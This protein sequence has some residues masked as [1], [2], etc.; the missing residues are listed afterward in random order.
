P[1]PA[2]R[3]ARARRVRGRARPAPLPPGPHGGHALPDRRG[4]LRR[5][6][7]R[8]AVHPP[9]PVA[10]VVARPA[11]PL[12]RG[13]GGGVVRPLVGARGRSPGGAPDGRRRG[14]RER[15]VTGALVLVGTPI[16]N[17]G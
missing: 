6:R 2:A 3:P 5:R 7:R 15:A 17:L 8:R 12:G 16:G 11:R 1:G 9:A 10:G 14:T 4:L 13:G